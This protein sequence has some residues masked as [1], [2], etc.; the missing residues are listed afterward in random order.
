MSN[1][2]LAEM[3]FQRVKVFKKVNIVSRNIIIT[4]NKIEYNITKPFSRISFLE[5]PFHIWQLICSFVVTTITF[6]FHECDPLN[7]T[8]YLFCTNISNTTGTIYGAVSAYPSGAPEITSSIWWVRDA[9]FS[10][11]YV[12]FCELLL[13]CY[14]FCDDKIWHNFFGILCYQYSSSLKLFSFLTVL[15]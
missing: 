2:P 14:A 9:Q 5:Y 13:F 4:F 6:P 12:V 1:I 3:S 8:Y 15:I 11:F 10:F 7:Y